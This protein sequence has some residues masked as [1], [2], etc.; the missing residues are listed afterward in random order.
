MQLLM[1]KRLLPLSLSLSACSTLLP[2][3]FLSFF[4]SLHSDPY[5][6]NQKTFSEKEERADAG[7]KSVAELAEKNIDPR[8]DAED[9][10]S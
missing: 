8:R 3:L 6:E 1:F 2:R 7:E 9:V 10:S 4:L 5:S